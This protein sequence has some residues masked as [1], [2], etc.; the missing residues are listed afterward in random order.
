MRTFAQANLFTH[1][2]AFIG[3]IGSSTG[4][5]G[6]LLLSLRDEHSS[7]SFI[8]FLISNFCWLTHSLKTRTYSMV[9]MQVGYT[10]TS[11][12]GIYNWLVL[13]LKL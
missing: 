11:L 4:L 12:Y 13:P 9:F 7:Y 5:A 8:L 1:R 2:Y 10:I 6:S 3:W